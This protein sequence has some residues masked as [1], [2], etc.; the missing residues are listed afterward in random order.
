VIVH[1]AAASRSAQV[2]TGS[3]VGS[4]TDHLGLRYLRRPAIGKVLSAQ[5]EREIQIGAK[6]RF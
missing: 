5:P 1:T 4:V 3:I 6:L 2:I